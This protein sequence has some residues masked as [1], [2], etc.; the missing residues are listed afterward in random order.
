MIDWG[1]QS[2]K[3]GVEYC[4]RACIQGVGSKHASKMSSCYWCQWS[5]H[6]IL[7]MRI[8]HTC[9][10]FHELEYK[11]LPSG[12]LFWPSSISRC[13]LPPLFC[14]NRL[15]AAIPNLPSCPPASSIQG[16]GI[17]K[18][19]RA[20]LGWVDSGPNYGTRQPTWNHTLRENRLQ[21][22]NPS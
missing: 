18:W 3:L 10:I 6:K 12:C 4:G 17:K 7:D 15:W 14:C 20:G 22:W 9:I 19:Y 21:W 5:F 13:P 11:I 16:P 1:R 2:R 8:Y